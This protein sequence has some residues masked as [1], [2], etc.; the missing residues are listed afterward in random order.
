MPRLPF[1]QLLEHLA[2]LFTRHRRHGQLPASRRARHCLCL[3][4]LEDR[5]APATLTVNTTL[6]ESSSTDGTLSLRMAILSINQG[7]DVQGATHVGSYGSN[8]TILFDIP[9][10]DPGYN[11]AAGAYTIKLNPTL[12]QL[13]LSQNVAI[14]GPG[15]NQLAVSGNNASSVFGVAPGV[16]ATLSGLTIENGQGGSGGGIDNEG[17]MLTVSNCTLSGNSA[18]SGGGICNSGTLTVNNS[19]LSG[20]SALGSGGGIYNAGTLNLSNS[21]LYGNSAGASGGGLYFASGPSVL[22]NDTITDNVCNSSGAD[23]SGGGIAGP[24]MDSSVHNSPGTTL[25]NTIVAGNFNGTSGGIADD[26]TGTVDSASASNLIGTVSTVSSG[27]LQD[28]VNG[29]R[30]GGADPGLAPLADY[31]GPTQTVALLPGSPALGAGSVALAVDANGNPLLTD[32]RGFGYLRTVNNGTTIDIGAYQFQ[33]TLSTQEFLEGVVNGPLPTDPNTGNPTAVLSLDTQDQANAFLSVFSSTNQTPLQ[34]PAGAT[35][36]IDVSVSLASGIQLN[37]AN[38]SIPAG[39]RVSINGGTWIGGSP[40]LTLSSG[41]LTVTNATFQNDTDAPTILVTGGN[42]ELRNDLVES[43]TGFADAAISVT[44]GSLDLG[45]ATDPGGNTINVKGTGTWFQNA[46]SSPILFSGDTFEINGTAQSVVTWTGAD[47]NGEWDDPNNWQDSQGNARLPGP[48]DVALITQSGITV[49]HDENVDDSVA[50]VQSQAALDLSGGLLSIANASTISNA[51][52]LSDGG[53]T[54]M[55]DLTITGTADLMGSFLAPLDPN[56]GDAGTVSGSGTLYLDGGT[57][58]NP[59]VISNA[60][61]ILDCPVVNNG[62]AQIDAT[63]YLGSTATLTNGVGATVAIQDAA[64]IQLS[65]DLINSIM[66][67]PGETFTLISNQG[68][69]TGAFAGLPEGA[70]FN[71]SGYQFQISYAGGSDHQD[72]T[73]TVVAPTVHVAANLNAAAG[74]DTV[75][76]TLTTMDLIPA[77]QSA[78]FSYA[79]N[80]GDG[81]TLQT[82]SGP[83]SGTNPSWTYG[84]D[85]VYVVSVTATDVDGAV[86]QTATALVVVSTAANDQISLSGSTAGQ[87]QLAVNSQPGASGTYSPTDL[88]YVSGQEVSGSDT[89]TVNFGST[90]T[91]PIYLFGGGASGDTLVV[92]GDHSS[93]NVITKTLGQITWGNPVTETVYRSGIL[94]TT[95]NA[96]GTSNNYVNDPGGNTIINGG[97]GANTITITAATGNGVVING[98]PSSNNYVIDLGSLTAPVAIQNGNAGAANNLTVNG[99]AG[100]NTITASGN[101]VTEGSQT[102]TVTAPLTSAAI[103]GGSGNNQIT[104]SNLTV[105]V[106]T[107]SL[108]G[109]GNDTFT[110]DNLG[111][112]VGSLAITG[113][114]TGTN[115]VQVQGSLPP[116]STASWA[117]TTTTLASSAAHNTSLYGQMVTFTATVSANGSGAGT[118]TGSVDFFDT[119]TNTDLGTVNLSGGSASLTTANLAAGENAITATYSGAGN[120]L[121]STATPLHQQ[122]SA[123]IILLDPTG[124]G[125]LTDTGNGNVDVQGGAIVVDSSNSAAVVVSGNGD[126]KAPLLD[127]NGGTSTTGNGKIVGQVQSGSAADP[128]ASLAAPDPSSLTVQSTS[129]LSISGNQT[130]TLNPGVYVGGIQI[131][132]NAQVTLKS[133]IYYVEGGGFSVS[134]NGSVTDLGKGVLIYNA[135]RSASETISLTGN[136]KVNLSPMASGPYQGITLF[137]D[138]NSTAPITVTGNGNLDIT[139]AIYAAHALLNVTANADVDAQGNPLDS[140]GLALIVYDLKISGNGDFSVN[141]PS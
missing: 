41:D 106:Q 44:G 52:T 121:G 71:V 119:T 80:W 17:G 7:G 12:G 33:P 28:G 102:I 96:N 73:L 89:Y 94:N 11:S 84:S 6:D 109:S 107:L 21:T 27:D 74:P 58:A 42:L 83:G 53:L 141:V 45:T 132:D 50:S 108:T 13:P 30:V 39:F 63:V 24:F 78:D 61:L 101:Q 31:G 136:G 115:Q 66:P 90:L 20:N 14:E 110:L 111:T 100:D 16:T 38:L 64:S 72:V 133:G 122:A 91:T 129:R 15:A 60:T 88:V 105:P 62:S 135:P 79:I 103:D 81:S 1:P 128:L 82:L 57:A 124:Q 113:S 29:N 76:L 70:V 77:D 19:T 92:N 56:R 85:G 75:N 22:T 34:P 35:G 68:S 23:S 86:S 51:L 67:P 69:I 26:V 139:G 116:L 127:V 112:D 43:S 130:V 8:D 98:G 4:H 49:A 2:K 95:I 40:A 46:T 137:Q 65:P 54:I 5:L 87:V 37:E 131:G 120:F 97:P 25:N 114:P 126:L 59:N 32:Q 47:D 138:R 3:E 117:V 93:T 55:S 125:A 10:T 36:P 99:A 140:V 104:V 48:S 18:T 9:M 123:G 134:G 118:P